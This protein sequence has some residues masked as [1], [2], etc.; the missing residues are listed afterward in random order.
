MHT[1]ISYMYVNI[2]NYEIMKN[3]KVK[4]CILVSFYNI[5]ILY[6]KLKYK[7]E[8]FFLMYLSYLR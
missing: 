1:Y 2:K 8:I 3:I 7:Y 4:H 6:L 5:L